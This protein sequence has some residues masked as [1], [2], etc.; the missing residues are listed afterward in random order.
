M[1][2]QEG[3]PFRA[4]PTSAD[5]LDLPYLSINKRI[6]LLETSATSPDPLE[7]NRTNK[8]YNYHH[9]HDHNTKNFLAQ[10]NFT[11]TYRG[12]VFKGSYR[13]VQ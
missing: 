4:K 8:N 12:E 6:W 1:S 11:R 10:K 7:K 3:G 5:Y 2:R 13:S 9:D